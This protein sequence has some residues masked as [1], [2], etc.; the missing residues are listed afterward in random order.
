[1]K[2]FRTSDV[3]VP[4]GMPKLTYVSRAERNLEDRLRAANDNLCKLV[5]ITGATKSGKTVLVS[6]V[7]PRAECLWIDGG[8]VREED[9]L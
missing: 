5:T 8:T 9:D 7:F 2:T 4:G 1:M 3:F 6:Q